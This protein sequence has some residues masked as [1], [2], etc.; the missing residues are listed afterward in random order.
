MRVSEL[1]RT[2]SNTTTSY[3]AGDLVEVTHAELRRR[4]QR[5]AD[6]KA[7][8]DAAH[9]KT[10]ERLFFSNLLSIKLTLDKELESDFATN[11]LS[12]QELFAELMVRKDSFLISFANGFEFKYDTFVVEIDDI[13]IDI[14]NWVICLCV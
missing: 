11:K 5:L 4:I 2:R 13:E 10:R 8:T 3:E 1:S 7:R 9:L 12:A 14:C 6:E